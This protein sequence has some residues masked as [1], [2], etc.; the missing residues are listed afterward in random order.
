VGWLVPLVR[1]VL[2]RRALIYCHGDDLVETDP[3]AIARRRRVFA[4]A[5]AVVAA[6]DFAA[7]RLTGAYGVPAAKVVTIRNGVDLARFGSR[8]EPAGL[9]EALGAEGQRVLLAPTRLVPRK[10]VDRLIAALPAILAGEPRAM[11]VVAGDGPQRAALEHAAQGL[12]VRFLGA[13]APAEMPGLYALAELV[14]LPNRAEPGESDGL[15]LVFLEAN[16]AGQPVIGGRAGGTEEAVEDGRNGLLVA[17]EDP[18]AIAAA[19]TR[20]LADPA[21]A[22]RL[23]AGARAVAAER[24]WAGRAAA[25]VELCR[26]GP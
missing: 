15:P 10:G 20:V 2:R 19:V 16:A 7:E 17:G 24:G 12:P 26:R 3:R 11:L 8:P 25:F 9:R 5:D 13:V 22:A 23:A 6:G 18:A 21:L 14:V 1:R 4:E